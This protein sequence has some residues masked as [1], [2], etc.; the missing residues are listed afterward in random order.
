MKRTGSGMGYS[1][2]KKG[3]EE[4]DMGQVECSDL[5]YSKYGDDNPKELK[6]NAD[7]LARYVRNN[8]NRR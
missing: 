1:A 4:K 6:E 7:A 3:H 8:R 2:M 5:K